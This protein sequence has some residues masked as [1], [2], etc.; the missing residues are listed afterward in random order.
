MQTLF[1]FWNTCSQLFANKMLHVSTKRHLSKV[2]HGHVHLPARE[3]TDSQLG[4]PQL[5]TNGARHLV[6][7]DH[8]RRH[9][10]SV[11]GGRVLGGCGT[12]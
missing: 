11:V 5:L 4:S 1:I 12:V 2:H 3:D 9:D 10:K 7:D 8:L 6:V